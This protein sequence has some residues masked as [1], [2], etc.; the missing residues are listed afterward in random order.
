MDL[1]EREVQFNKRWD[2]T[3][4]DSYEE[5]FSKF[6][7]RILNVFKDIDF[8]VSSESRTKFCQYYAISEKVRPSKN[9]RTDSSGII[10]LMLRQEN[11]E[12][13]FY[14]LIEIIL[15]L[16]ISKDGYSSNKIYD[17]TKKNIIS[18]IEEAIKLSEVNVAITTGRDIYLYPKGEE[19]LDE[20]LVNVPL[21]FLNSESSQ[22]F[23]DALKFYDSHN[24][25]ESA[26]K[27]RRTLEE[28]LRYK[29]NNKKGFKE[30]IKDIEAALKQ[31]GTNSQVASIIKTICNY[32]DHYF[33]DQSK[34]NRG[35]IIEEENEFLI[36]QVGVLL[37]YINNAIKN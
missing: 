36:Y 15:L 35:N 24:P 23:I 32:L 27:L 34:H 9:G 16:D 33:N 26:E 31:K 20:E 3:T 14:R 5:A 21:S 8:Q 17:N 30:N 2:I 1:K 10:E 13:E 25:I 37:R 29:L 28:F 22:E 6:K 4:T 7:T 19:L 11:N 18:D 12:K